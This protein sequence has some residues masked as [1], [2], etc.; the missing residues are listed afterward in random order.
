MCWD[1]GLQDFLTCTCQHSKLS[2]HPLLSTAYIPDKN[3][4]TESNSSTTLTLL[5]LLYQQ[6]RSLGSA[7]GMLHNVPHIPAAG[8][9]LASLPP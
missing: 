1:P 2:T 5:L 7:V 9:V 8:T 4:L 3:M 6:Q